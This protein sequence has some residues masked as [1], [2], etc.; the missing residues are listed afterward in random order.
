MH[1]LAEKHKWLLKFFVVSIQAGRL[2]EFYLRKINHDWWSEGSVKS[3]W[4]PLIQPARLGINFP[5][6]SRGEEIHNGA[7]AV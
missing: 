6:T 4:L 2:D 5:D 7:L 1:I 3:G